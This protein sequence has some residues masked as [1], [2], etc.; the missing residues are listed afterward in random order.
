MIVELAELLR[1]HTQLA[2][3]LHLGVGE[4]MALARVDPLLHL[5][6][7]LSF[8]RHEIRLAALHLI[9]GKGPPP[10]TAKTFSSNR[11]STSWT[12]WPPRLDE[13]AS[14][15][16]GPKYKIEAR[17]FGERRE[18]PIPRQ[19][20]NASVDTALGDQRVTETRLAALCQHLRS[21]PSC[22]LP[23]VG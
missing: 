3:H 11:V 1:V 14:V 15:R 4:V 18:V 10:H 23:V 22:P 17:S 19:K 9:R 16:S 5:L 7:R 2:S 21:Q 8:L 12:Y 6:V 13:I 20:R